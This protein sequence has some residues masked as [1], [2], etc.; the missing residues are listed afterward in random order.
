MKDRILS[1]EIKNYVGKEVLLQ[2]W[3]HKK[4]LLGGLVFIL[5]RDRG[6]VTQVLIEDK[7][8]AQKLEGLQLGTVLEI[9]G[10]V[11]A[12]ERAPEGI[13]IHNPKITVILPV[14]EVSP[15][16]IDKPLSHKSENLDTLFEYRVVGVRNINE[17]K[18]FKI[19]SEMN[20]Y[21]REFL[22]QNEFV[23][24]QTPK[25]LAGATEGGA[26][27]F[28]FDYFGKEATLAQSPQFY[29]QIMVG[30]F[31]RVFEIGPTFRAEPS[32]TSRHVSEITMLDIEMGFIESH[33]DVLKM[34]ENLFYNI[35]NRVYEEHA[36]ELKSLNA[37]ELVLRTSFP[38]YSLKTIH[39][40]YT[41]ATGINTVGEKDMRPEE[42]KWICDFSKKENGCEAVF[43]TE[44]P[45]E[46]MKFYHMVNPKDPT[47]VCW[48]DLLFRGLEIAT[49]PMREHHYDKL[50]LQMKK[51]G[52]DP[53]HPGYKYYLQAFK[54]GLPPHGG[55]GF[56]IDR[57]VEKTI[58]LGNVKEAILFPRDMNRL[59]P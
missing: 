31:E 23:E 15:I 5:L 33:D 42:E 10:T 8:E 19:R 6:G 54:F 7:E 55:F 11:V 2:G 14:I 12:E 47:T 58:G 26:E 57:L 38:R 46:S 29:K 22:N 51:A 1:R 13:E 45:V 9:V 39:E 41:K 25:I 16:E 24:I 56:G 37:P 49:C 43:V 4:R 28:K 52:I 36:E 48:A 30:A 40:M 18:V 53:E 27:V 34:T 21:I 32:T 50:V 35:L 3:L 44:F 20:R 59:T 17:G